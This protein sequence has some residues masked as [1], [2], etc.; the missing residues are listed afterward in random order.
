[1]WARAQIVGAL[2]TQQDQKDHLFEHLN[3]ENT[4]RDMLRMVEAHGQEKLQYWGLSYV[5]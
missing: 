1:M 3:T 4:A 5:L 2:A